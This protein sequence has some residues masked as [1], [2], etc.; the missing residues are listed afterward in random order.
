MVF[1]SK[2]TFIEISQVV[3][4]HSISRGSE[5]YFR[6]LNINVYFTLKSVQCFSFYGLSRIIVSS[7][8]VHPKENLLTS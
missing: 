8:N 5:Q 2:Q 3:D 1:E 7:S 4:K 6:V